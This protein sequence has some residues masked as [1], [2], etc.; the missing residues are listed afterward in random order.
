[1]YTQAK[2]ESAGHFPLFLCILLWGDHLVFTWYVT[3]AFQRGGL[4]IPAPDTPRWYYARNRWE[5]GDAILARLNDAPAS[6]ERVQQT[7]REILAAI[8]AETEA[9]PSIHWKQFL[10]LGFVHKTG[11]NIIRRLCLC[12]WLPM[13]RE[14]MGSSLIV[15]YSCVIL[16]TVTRPHLVSRISGVLNTF[17]ALGCVPLT[18][19]IERVG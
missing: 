9:S 14:W 8:E 5:E 16:S 18:F 19:T 13:I 4:L 6:S 17:F 11:M 3:S 15:Y 2:L 10:G 7:R 1:M 12:F